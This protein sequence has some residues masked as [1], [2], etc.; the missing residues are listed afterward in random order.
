MNK[1]YR[2]KKSEEIEKIIQEKIYSSN[3][4][5]SVYKKYNSETSHFRFAI[6]VGKKLGNAVVRNKLKRQIR[7]IVS[8]LN[9]KLD[10]NT[11][12]FIIAK[13]KV[14]ELSYDEML[15]QLEYLFTKQKLIIKG[16][17]ND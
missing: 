7:A 10:T 6:S 15:K 3:Q 17:K 13:V 2:V 5:F 9:I 8:S 4:Y 1:Q 16:A 12:V 14:L 11:D